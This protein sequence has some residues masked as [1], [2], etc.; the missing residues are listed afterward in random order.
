M[1][2]SSVSLTDIE[3]AAHRIEPYIRKTPLLESGVLRKNGIRVFLKFESEQDTRAFK[4][5]GAYNNALQLTDEEKRR[6]LI[7]G[8]AGN[9]AKALARVG[10]VLGIPVTIVMP[11]DAPQVKIKDTLDYG[12][13]IEFCKRD[14]ENRDLIVARLAQESGAVIVHS[15]NNYRTIA[16]QGTIGLEINR[17]SQELGFQPDVLAINCSGGGLSSGIA[18][19]STGFGKMPEI[20]IVEPED[21]DDGR[22]TLQSG[23]MQGNAKANGSICDGLLLTLGDKTFPILQRRGATGIVAS[24]A[25]VQA[26][27]SLIFEEFGKVVEPSGAVSLAAVIR[28]YELFKGK[29]VV[30][31]ISGGNVDPQKFDEHI[32]AG[33]THRQKL[34]NGLAL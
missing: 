22:R 25:E 33:N 18:E 12:A 21:F 9:H 10:Q 19:A 29:N 20:F 31:V 13:K 7:A 32:K 34:L 15:Y 24:D 30:A 8:S 5:R 27:M 17:Q 1:T 2:H 26:A 28:H 3:A 4:I 11:D 6:G 16:G 23:A 14:G